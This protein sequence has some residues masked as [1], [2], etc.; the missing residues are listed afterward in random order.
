ME[1]QFNQIER[2]I[3][4]SDKILILFHESPDGDTI[5]SSL[6]LYTY[7]MRLGKKVDL[8]VKGEIPAFFTFLTSP[9]KILNDF[10]L[11]DYDLIFAIDCGDASRTGFP[12]RIEQVSRSRILINIDHHLRNDLHKIA[13]LN[14]VDTTVSSAAEII[15]DILKYLKFEIDSRIATYILSGIY[16]DTGG[17]QHSNVS[18]KTLKIASECLRSGAR[19]GLISNNISNSKSS[20]GLKLWGKALEKMKFK[21]GIVSTYLTVDDIE[22]CEAKGEDA[23]GVAN[24]INTMPES[25]L[26]VLFLE[27]SDGKI[28]ASL[29]TEDDRVDVSLLARLFGGGGHRKA[30]GFT[31]EKSDFL[32]IVNR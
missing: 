14:V 30:A 23:A 20:S 22:K 5:S 16:Y 27:S 7:L 11:G 13:T 24:L 32:G 8:G 3:S 2:Y 29:R 19:M 9:Y 18:T 4:K 26:S 31:L 17:F 12:E 15:F 25:R 28:K 6:A 1:K 21:G 10:L